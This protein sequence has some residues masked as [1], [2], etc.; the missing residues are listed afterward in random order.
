MSELF[1]R[2]SFRGSFRSY[3]QAVLDESE[4]YLADKKLHIVAAPGSGK[5]VLGLELIRRVDAPTLIL[6]PSVTVRQQWGERFAELFLPE[7]EKLEDYVSDTLGSPAP[8]C[9][10]TYQALHA[11]SRPDETGEPRWKRA[12]RDMQIGTLCLDE[13]HHL[14]S[15]WQKSLEALLDELGGSVTVIALTATPPYDSTP[16][17]WAR[18]RRVCGEIDAEI[19]VPELVA[20]KTL[21]PHQDY[22]YF[23]IGRHTV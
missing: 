23:K 16:A 5:T 11:A 10:I 18:Y 15:E 22:V 19:F 4:G 9:S 3:Q 7:G 1:S 6:S 12:V 17:E 8:I 21:C 13:A 2:V 20:Q 14:R